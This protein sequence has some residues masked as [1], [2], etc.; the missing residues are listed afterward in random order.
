MFVNPENIHDF[1]T[2]FEGIELK[3]M[4]SRHTVNLQKTIRECLDY[5][6]K[7]SESGLYDLCST[8][9]YESI[10]TTLFGSSVDA[11]S[12]VKDLKSF[13]TDV[14][15]LAYPAPYRWFKPNLIRSRNKIAKRLSSVKNDDSE[16]VFVSKLNEL[17]S[18]LSKED[19]GSINMAVLWAAY[20]N[21][22]P[23]IFWTYFYLRRYPNIYEIILREI[24]SAS[25]EAKED[26]LIY[27][28]PHLD[29]VM[30]ET[31][32]LTANALIV[33]ECMQ[34]MKLMI[35]NAGYEIS[36]AENDILILFPFASQID[37]EYF[38]RPHEFVHDRFVIGSPNQ[39]SAAAR[40]IHA[41]FGEGKFV[42]PGR[43]LGKNVIKW[44]IV[45]MIKQF[46]I[47]FFDDCETIK[48][49]TMLKSRQGFGIPPPQKDI[50]IRYRVK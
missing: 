30:E 40:R 10:T 5:G 32:R 46:D 15:L 47:D 44:T 22:I 1:G 3:K 50:R 9:V 25:S 4:T 21:V 38:P 36:L 24:E 35:V 6:E 29:G 23:A 20:G 33:R 19:V 13:D 2:I 41:P 42:C 48:K 37:E 27:S 34:D 18:L 43:L 39:A 49:P 11:R 8:L 14:H 26:D 31:M 7:W 17:A 12:I 28:M 45:A 16:N